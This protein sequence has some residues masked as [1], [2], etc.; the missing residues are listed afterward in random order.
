MNKLSIIMPAYNEEKRI[1]ITLDKYGGF[2][3]KAKKDKKISD[4]EIIV[5][6]NACKDNTIGIVKKF[7]KKYREIRF[8]NFKQG[9]KGFAV[10]EGFIDALKRDNNLIGFV[11][12][13]MATPPEAFYDLVRNI[14]KYDGVIASRWGKNSIIRSKQPIIRIITSRCFNFIVRSILLLNLP[15]TQCGAK[16]F[17]KK[18]LEGFIENIKFA[19][20]AFDVEFLYRLKKRGLK[21]KAVPTIW[22]DK[23]GSKVNLLKVPFQMFASVMR[24]RLIYSP[25]GFIVRLYDKLPE[26]IKIQNW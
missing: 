9:G 21:I 19:E 1:G 12:A 24:L 7:K 6:L 20:W 11:D 22:E 15:D 5:V 18:G 13:D 14:G 10:T 16:L 2:F 25:F 17:K 3:Q 8:L 26:K 4:F 23:K